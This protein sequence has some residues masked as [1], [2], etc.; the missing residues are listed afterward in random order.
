MSKTAAAAIRATFSQYAMVKTR[1]VLVL[2]ME[3]PLEQQAEV[4]AALGYPLPGNEVWCAVARLDVSVADVSVEHLDRQSVD[5]APSVR[6]TAAE[7]G[8]QRYATAS[9]MQ[10]ALTRAAL[11]PKDPRFQAWAIG[12]AQDG[13]ES[14]E[15]FVR[16]TCCAG[17]SRKLIAEDRVCFDAF[18]RMETSFLVETNQMAEP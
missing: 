1:G 18:I 8:K 7:R 15:Q 16:E 13:P 17:E 9:D 12:G 5:E 4:F 6:I 3:V 11:L 14:A 10:R 2:H